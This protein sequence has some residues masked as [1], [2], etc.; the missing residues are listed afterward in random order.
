[1]YLHCKRGFV[2]ADRWDGSPIPVAEQQAQAIACAERG[3][4]VI[5]ARS[6]DGVTLVALLADSGIDA[7]V[8]HSPAWD[9]P[10]RVYLTLDE[11]ALMLTG[12]AFAIDYR[13]FKH[14]TSA[15]QRGQYELAMRIWQAAYD[16]DPYR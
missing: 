8:F 13:N 14:W 9:Y 5:I 2:E 4:A 16:S 6:R 11:W 7:K 12:A 3:G 10:F 15:H 1:M